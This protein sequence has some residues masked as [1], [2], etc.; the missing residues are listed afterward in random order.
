[1]DNQTLIR[2]TLITAGAM[3]GAC[4]V[5]VGM[6]TLIASAAVGH[7]L[8]PA[9]GSVDGGT[10]APATNV[11]ATPG[12]AKAASGQTLR[13]DSAGRRDEGRR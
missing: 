5:V 11:R 13:G 6:L 9:G 7:A 8:A 3:V 12:A 4:V 10:L 1:M 2:R